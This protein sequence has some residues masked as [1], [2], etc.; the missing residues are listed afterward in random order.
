MTADN[1][2]RVLLALSQ[3]QPFQVFTVEL[4]GG[5]RFEIDHPRA[6]VVRDGVAVFLAPGGVPIW[7]DHDS[8]NQIIGANANSVEGE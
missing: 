5:Q 4:H 1:F 8:V 2:D 6:T 3:R 7:F